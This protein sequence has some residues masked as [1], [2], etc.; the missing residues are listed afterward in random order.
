MA[1]RSLVGLIAVL[2]V[3]SC[4]FSGVLGHG[5]LAL[6]KGRNYIANLA[7]QDYCVTC[8]SAGGPSVTQSLTP[9]GLYPTP[10]ETV[11]SAVRHT[12]CGESA[13][14]AAADRHYNPYPAPAVSAL[15][16]YTPG[17]D[18][19]IQIMITAHHRGHFEFRLCDAAKLSDPTTVTWACLDQNLLQRVSVP[20]EI[21]PVDVNHPERYYLEPT[22][23]TG[24]NVTSTMKYRIPSNVTCE[25]CILQWWWTSAN[26]CNPP[27]YAAR[28]PMPTYPTGCKWW[29]PTLMA[30]GTSYPEEFWNC[31]DIRVA[32]TASPPGVATSPPPPAPKAPAV[33]VAPKAAPSAAPKAPAVVAPAAPKAPPAAPTA[34]AAPV[35]A[36]VEE[37]CGGAGWAGPTCCM[38]GYQCYAY[39]ASYSQ[40]RCGGCPA[41]WL[42]QGTYGKSLVTSAVEWAKSLIE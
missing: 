40:C 34:P 37:Q 17:S 23:A 42:C 21:S 3:W 31:A 5:Y 8:L 2:L 25:R 30:C 4:C 15:P 7:G 6:P 20:G 22:C 1:C 16:V 27:A 24:Y 38:Q 35:C 28:S 39:T 41:G 33:P 9:G 29:E 18:I 14:M 36:R 13:A 12:Q 32:G 11:T 19:D 10:T 26:T